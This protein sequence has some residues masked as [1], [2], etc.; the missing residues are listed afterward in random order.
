MALTVP[1]PTARHVELGI[2]RSERGGRARFL[3]RTP[4][5][6]DHGIMSVALRAVVELASQTDVH[7][8]LTLPL[9][10][11]EPSPV[12]GLDSRRLDQ[13]LR[14]ACDKDLVERSGRHEG[15]GSAA[16][17]IGLRPTVDGLRLIGHWPPRGDEMRP[18]PW[19]AHEWGNTDRRLLQELAE[20]PPLHGYLLRPLGGGEDDESYWRTVQRLLDAGLIGGKRDSEGLDGMLITSEGERALGASNDD[21]LNAARADLA[22]GARADAMTAVESVLRGKLR[23]VA[24]RAEVDWRREDGKPLNPGELNNRLAKAGAYDEPWRAEVA[25][26]LAIRNATNHDV[27]SAISPT[28]IDRAIASVHEFRDGH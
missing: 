17:W 5:P 23:E 14:E 9:T 7:E 13:R 16:I 8:Q 24:E 4:A 6:T 28:R 25:W 22:R 15:D 18:G 10:A 26:A 27:E 21:P 1:G 2:L 19:D 3:D 20:E 11:P 12:D